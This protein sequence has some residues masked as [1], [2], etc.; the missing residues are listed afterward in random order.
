MIVGV[1][2]DDLP[3][4]GR[5]GERQPKV[6]VVVSRLQQDDEELQLRPA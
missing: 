5:A 4:A 2:G 1:D 6:L 3:M